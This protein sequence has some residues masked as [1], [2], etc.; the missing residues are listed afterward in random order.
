MNPANSRRLPALPPRLLVLAL[1]TLLGGRPANGAD[2]D[3]GFIE[4]FALAGDREATLGQLVPGTE[5]HY[6][7]HALHQQ[8]SGQAATFAATMA[9][10]A[11]R[12][13]DS[14]QRRMLENREAL[15]AYG[16]DPQ[17][18]LRH[19]RERLGLQFDHAPRLPDQKP[20]LPTSLDAAVVSRE[21]FLGKVLQRDSL[22]GLSDD[23]SDRLVR[24]QVPLRPG[25]RRTLLARLQRP[26]VPGLVAL[27]LADLKTPESRGFGEF[28][29]HR[30]LLPEQLDALE[31]EVPALASQTAFVLTR[32]RRLAPGADASAQTDPVER[33]AWLER[34]G[35]H[36]RGLPPSF[37]SLKAQVLF[38][39]LQHDRTRGVYDRARFLEYLKLPRPVGYMS[40]KYL[41]SV[42]ADRHAVDL[43]ATFPES[44]LSLP[45][46]GM[47]EPLVRE[48][49]LHFAAT[50]AAWEP[51]T[52]WLNDA[53]VKPLFAEAK[54]TAGAGEP[55]R[56]A[57]LLPP[58]AYQALKDR[59]DIEFPATNAPVLPVDQEVAVTVT[60]KNTPQVMVR[61]FEINT[62]GWF[63]SQKRPL[64]TD[65]PLDGWVA[66]TEERHDGESSP[67]LR[68][69]RR[70][71]FPEL[72]GRRG[73]WIIEVIG[74]GR[75]SRALIRR[76]G[77]RLLQ[78]PG[79]GGDLLRVLDENARV[80]TNAVAWL[81]GRKW[82]ADPKDGRI[83]I[84]FTATPGRRPL[85][86]SEAEGRLASLA[87]FEHHAET[88]ALEAWF[89]L[90][91]EQCVAGAEAVLAIRSS[92][93]I[94][95]HAASPE[96][97]TEPRLTLTTVTHDGVGSTTAVDLGA[98]NL[99]PARLL[100]RTF[101][102]PDRLARVTATLSGRIEPVAGGEKRE[103]SATRT[104]EINGLERTARV[105]DAFLR[106]DGENHRIEV[107]GRNGEP[108]PDQALRLV[109]H[110]RGFVA[111]EEASLRT[112]AQGRIQ[113]GRLEDL[114]RIEVFAENDLHRSWPL[115]TTDR[116]RARE[117]HARVGETV[118]IPWFPRTAPDAWSLLELRGGA[119]V[120][121][122]SAAVRPVGNELEITGLPAGDYS[123]QLRDPAVSVTTL[124][125]TDGVPVAG[126][127]VGTNRS[128]ELRPRPPVHLASVV[129]TRAGDAEIRVLNGNRSTRVHV[130]AGHFVPDPGL[131]SSLGGF[132]RAGSGFRTPD[133][134]P[135]LYSAG[136]AI[137]DE[138]RYILDR[139]YARKYPGHGVARPGLLLNPWDKRSTESVALPVS[140]GQAPLAAMG[141][142]PGHLAM[143]ESLSRKEQAAP[144]QAAGPKLDFLAGGALAWFNLLPDAEGRIRLPAAALADRPV[145]QVQ[146]EDESEAAWQ[147]LAKTTPT[148]ATQDLRLAKSPEAA[149]G[150]AEVRES[151][152]LVRGQSLTL[153]D[154]RNSRWEAYETLESVF[155]LLRT[156]NPDPQLARFDWLMRWPSL[157]PEEQRARYSE[158]A[159]HEVNLFLQRKDPR[160]FE[161]VIRPHLANQRARTFL[162]DY[163]LGSDLKPYREPRAHGRLNVAEKALLAARLDGEAPVTARHLQELWELLPAD[164]EGD[165]RRFETALG[166]RA[167]EDSGGLGGG[168]GFR[169]AQASVE[170]RRSDELAVAAAAPAFDSPESALM[171]RYGLRPP[172]RPVL[173][174]DA[175]AK[176]K[177]SATGRVKGARL[178]EERPGLAADKTMQRTP[179]AAPAM[180]PQQARDLRIRA[181]AA[182][183][184][185]SPGPA[186]EWAENHYHRLPL[187]AQGPD[188][189]PVS[190]FWRDFAAR[191]PAEPFLSPRVLEAHHHPTEILLALAL[192]DLPFQATNA[193]TIRREGASRTL[194]ANGPLLVFFREVRPA[195]PNPK[196]GA[197]TELLLSERFFRQDD[198]FVQDGQE[199]RDKFVTDEFL[200][201]VVYG[202][203]V[204]VGN[205]GSSPVK[206][207]LL[208]RIPEGSMPVLGS[209][210]TH[211]QTV[212]IEPYST[213]MKEYHF[214]F[215]TPAEQP[216][217]HAHAP[218]HL[219]QDGRSLATAPG[220]ALRVV[221]RLSARDTASWE[222]VSQ[223]GT[224]AEVLA[225][226]ATNNLARLDLESVAWRAR[227]SREFFGRL[228]GFLSLHHVWNEPVARYAV[229]HN[230]AEVLR[231]WLRHRPDF[232]SQCGP[233]LE[234][235]LLRIDPVE[236]RTYEH[237]EYSPLINPRAHPVG[238][239]R[240]IANPVFRDQY[241][242]FLR[243]LA[244]QPRLSPDDELAMAYYLFLQ[245]RF[246][247]GLAHLERVRP[248]EIR[249]RIQYDHL[250]AWAHLLEEKPAE[251]RKIAKAYE[252]YPV[253]RWRNLFADLTRHLDEAEGKAVAGK[254][255]NGSPGTPG[256]K[257]APA[258][259]PSSTPREASFD[260]QVENRTVS[261][262]WKG[263]SSVTVN[264]HRMDP[265]FLFSRSP[266]ADRDGDQ[267]AI[268]Q[269]TL[270]TVVPLPAGK[271]ALEVPIPAALAKDHVMVEVL[272]GGRRKAR[273]HHAH[274][275]RLQLAESE[276]M[277]EVR[278]LAANRPL[279]KAYVKVYGR[280]DTGEIRFVKD[281]Y[282][283]LRGR[284]DYIGTNESRN[285]EPGPRSD[286]LEATSLDHAALAP[287]EGAR[288]RRV[289]VL[290][291][292]ETHGAAVREVESPAR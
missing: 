239:R 60:L 183:Y 114:T 8:S 200:A 101:R 196:T 35:N 209:R 25:Q 11:E 151:R 133:H 288:I 240:R 79:P 9:Q 266:F 120:A 276:G 217:D 148:L 4:T 76:G 70:F 219:T 154:F 102:V 205:P 254:P 138:S 216:T 17:R 286:G 218:A 18:T 115:G 119:F 61:L 28:A 135:N 251:A 185:R 162:D 197:G 31:K 292:S 180:D 38:A 30:V 44:G 20:D 264:Y 192:L 289:A 204:V 86:L 202:A 84:P 242:R 290:V 136:R 128:L 260:L 191:N 104:W 257:A 187:E 261:I 47:D 255:A 32:I 98:T 278:D 21:A 5:E 94:G 45:P 75:S 268:L 57:S 117:V 170:G 279:S 153:N 207:E 272:G 67:F 161:T 134:L 131:F 179:D 248:A 215:P 80:V 82:E 68:T 23:E 62:L 231:E 7:F 54:I 113:L 282:T 168:A 152:G 87:E 88:Y 270:S 212:R 65:L 96:L 225:F 269:P 244:F 277:L 147:T 73:A 163:L 1:A 89:H 287:D 203:Q 232:L 172:D 50:E 252:S 33:E 150:A 126:W 95:D 49:F 132:T 245:D 230:D 233:W 16:K 275:F 40:P 221:R 285:A 26:D 174:R 10:W 51:W 22:E 81:D 182:G 19:L 157:S 58:A 235:P 29:I 43:N 175:S 106:R 156:L 176:S 220:G 122:R 116:T 90:D 123:L 27:I 171:S 284:F 262:T 83:Q 108:V 71:R 211:S 129:F 72:R 56:W 280:L 243:V 214:Y 34:V 186:R 165:A 110:R 14:E 267:P 59:V 97:L 226:L 66:N 53:W 63:L 69:S 210:S 173:E 184:Y 100:T 112:D 139:R 41:E 241:L 259:D 249:T 238:S 228:T 143:A 190:G 111:T 140:D 188:L 55:E 124:R 24:D 273:L 103:L 253:P 39:R 237:L 177:T 224:E 146:V 193:L 92:L 107:L 2:T 130:I 258:L 6:F 198:R 121:D 118:R 158:F 46:I 145:I 199:R 246:E 181:A 52:E 141:D 167:L 125:L 281:G 149:G 99:Q 229:L 164:P 109:F 227:Q 271:S 206:A 222:Y 105:Q 74:G 142:L 213:L 247:E 159:C 189:I 223:Q 48:F 64:N 234:S 155:G 208:T 37:N 274:T 201:G 265:E 127:L 85:V 93:R 42:R 160:F 250:R 91:P 194:A 236:E 137:G 283:D 15:L 12:F 36:V 263:L 166:G 3:I 78:S 178:S 291:L 256:G 144:P 13:P 169:R 77:Y 195:D